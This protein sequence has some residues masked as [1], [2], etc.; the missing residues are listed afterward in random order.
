M[1][2]TYRIEDNPRPLPEAERA[3]V[4]KSPGFGTS[5]TDHMFLAE[6]SP[7]SGW[8]DPRVVP[9]GPFQLD[10]AAA[11][12]HYGQEIFEGLKGYA[13]ADGSVWGFRLEANAARFQRSA[14]R[15][16]LPELPIE[17]FTGSVRALVERDREW[18]PT[19]PETSLYLR[20]FMF[21]SETFLGVRPA[22][23]ITY[24]VIAS[25]A[26]AY[27]PGGLKPVSIWLSTE[28]SRAAAGGTGAAKCGGNYAASLLPQQQAAENGCEQVV[29]LDAV[30]HNWVEELGGM[31]LFF[32]RTDGS[33]VTPELSGS[34][35]EGVTRDSIVTLAG[36]LGYQVVERKVS[37][38]EWREGVADGTISEVFACGTAAVITPVGSLK[39]EGGSVSSGSDEV[40][41][42][43]N[44]IRSA[45]VDLQYGRVEDR[46]GWMTKITD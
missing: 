12:L 16:A 8:N 43:T 39:W 33:I 25:P 15:L 36:D 11:V 38:G 44:Q 13:H 10:P 31:N 40:G 42:V 7:D 21:A 35:L 17:W 24:S 4:L 5:F 19:E 28:Y 34:I 18:V 22:Q 30:E 45:L 6:W 9:Y 32:V 23:H 3:A 29:F 1:T 37:I 46:Y 41:A 2:F 20:P 27:F 14:R 26:G